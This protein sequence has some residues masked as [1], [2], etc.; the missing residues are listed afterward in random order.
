MT[1][2]TIAG[3]IA[4]LALI[5]CVGVYS[6]KKVKNGN[7]FL[8]GGGRAGPGLVC[9]AILGSLVGGQSTIGTAQLAFHFGLSAWWFTLGSGLGCLFLALGFV[10]PLRRSG[11]V[12]EPQIL[13]REYGTGAEN[14]SSIL[15][16]LGVF[17]T[18]LVQVISCIGLFTIIFP[19]LSPFAAAALT[20][21][22]MCAYIVFGGAWGA[23]M[24]GMV[25][26][27]LL[28]LAFIGS[29]LI[30]LAGEGGLS[31]LAAALRVQLAG[32]PLSM[33]QTA[34]A[35]L[36]NIDG[37]TSL[38]A[39]FFTLLARGVGKDLG[40][41][42]SLILG[43]LSTQTYAQAVWSAGSDCAARRGV[44]LGAL[45]CPP[46]GAA[47]ILIGLSMRAHC[48]T[49]AEAAAL[50][51]AGQAVTQPVLESTVHVLPAFALSHMPPLC[52]GIVLGTLLITVICG[53]AGLTLGI[54]AILVK[55]VF[56]RFCGMSG[57]R[58]E[59][60][61]SRLTIVAVLGASA[62]VALTMPGALLN[63]LGFLSMGLRAGVVFMPMAA[64]LF[65]PGRLRSG[66]AVASM[67]I[68]P[69]TMA[70]VR[71]LR[72]PVDPLLAGM[73]AAIV[74]CGAGIA[75]SS[76]AHSAKEK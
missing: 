46:L 42:L 50:A 31:G 27:G 22:V 1:N 34:A 9:G 71:F 37:E 74:V 63:D 62:A 67:L 10:G 68:A 61:V 75:L 43:V 49:A 20:V 51:A 21:A 73:A 33:I 19:G 11:C 39:R 41:C 25:K 76:P 28:Y 26:V 60:T 13:R 35:G 40:S 14:L 12:T 72:L 56:G 54:S 65:A 17:I 3:I 57:G 52:A 55:D 66:F 2:M 24:G 45:L 30:V 47:G 38:A 59:L 4:V 48:V 69:L 53:G 32:T 36:S 5:S 6:G 44:L 70:A 64:A 18:V 58:A 8:T 16:A 29:L 7:D 23:G 15:S